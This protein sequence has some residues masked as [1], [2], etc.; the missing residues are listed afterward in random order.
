[1]RTKTVTRHYCDFCSKGSFKKPTM[2]EHETKCFSNP[3]RVCFMCNEMGNTNTRDYK[4]I[5]DNLVKHVGVSVDEDHNDSKEMTSEDAMKWLREQVQDCPACILA[6]L[7]QSGVM[8]FNFFDY[9]KEKE[10]WWSEKNREFRDM[11]F[12]PGESA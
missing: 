11:V 9:K 3:S 1:M 12:H 5:C 10:A 6:V 2:I 7:K 4:S 8:A